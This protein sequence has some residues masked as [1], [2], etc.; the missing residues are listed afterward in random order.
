MLDPKTGQLTEV[1]HHDAARF[2]VAGT[3]APG[4]TFNQDEESSGVIDVTSMLGNDERLAFL[5]D[6]QAHYAFAGAEFAEGGQLQLMYVDL[7]N[8]GD[9]R[10]DGTNGNDTFDGGFGDDRLNGGKGDD[11]LL[12]NYGDDRIDGGDG[13]DILDGGPGDDIV[14]GGKGNDKI[15][16]GTGDDDLKGDEGDD[17]IDG[18]VGNDKLDGGEGRD[19][20]SGGFGNDELNGGAGNDV[21]S[22]NQGNDD[23]AGGAGNDRLLGGSGVDH[24]AGGAG[25][26]FL[27]GGEGADVLEGGSGDDTY[28]FASP[29]D[30]GDTI[31]GFRSGQDVIQID[32]FNPAAV[33]LLGFEDSTSSGPAVGPALIYSDTTGELF[34]DPTGGS[35]DDQV[36]VATLTNSPELVRADILLV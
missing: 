8:P 13:D 19:T 30:G 6:T 16:G 17:T 14:Q 21:L 35:T 34:W 15:A 25:N 32:V 9:T 10:F 31:V 1:A 27:D 20:L 23:L 11:T 26:D 29:A 36:L 2:G 7:P 4:G 18:G 3:P 24:L 33:T 5:L 22:G 28:F 12:G